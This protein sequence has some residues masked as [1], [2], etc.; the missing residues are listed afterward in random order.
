MSSLSIA[1]I[2]HFVTG[3]DWLLGRAEG[4]GVNLVQLRDKRVQPSQGRVVV[5]LVA[6]AATA[7]DVAKI[8]NR[9]HGGGQRLQLVH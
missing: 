7:F 8:L 2:C 6:C 3:A 4:D 5:N 9:A 1:F